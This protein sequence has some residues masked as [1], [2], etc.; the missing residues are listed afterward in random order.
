MHRK[1]AEA[2]LLLNEFK[3]RA[4]LDRVVSL[5]KYAESTENTQLPIPELAAGGGLLGGLAGAGYTHAFSPLASRYREI[6]QLV[7]A[8]IT[9][10]DIER[11]VREYMDTMMRT[12]RE[13]GFT[14]GEDS[15]LRRQLYADYMNGA[16]KY[17][18]KNTFLDTAHETRRFWQTF[19]NSAKEALRRKVTKNAL[20][21]AA[22]STVLAGGGATLYNHL[23]D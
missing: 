20:I 3:K 21:A 9:D 14:K 11:N 13:S 17:W 22:I 15:L 16:D 5:L 18:N 1:Y 10:A 2:L 7:E 23:N 4:A 19:E 12:V 6:K 8:P